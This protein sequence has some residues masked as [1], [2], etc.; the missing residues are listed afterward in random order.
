M[1]AKT[2]TK[3]ATRSTTRTKHKDR[4]EVRVSYKDKPRALP[5]SQLLHGHKDSPKDHLKPRSTG[6]RS[7]TRTSYKYG[8]IGS[9]ADTSTW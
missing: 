9:W 8:S 7:A 2:V 4:H 6:T 3:M 5:Q 1:A